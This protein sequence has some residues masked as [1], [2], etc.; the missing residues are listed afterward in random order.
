MAACGDDEKG[1]GGVSDAEWQA[2][3]D[4]QPEN[5]TSYTVATKS[6]SS[7]DKSQAEEYGEWE[8]NTVTVSIDKTN[9]IYVRV[10]KRETYNTASGEFD[11]STNT[12]YGFQY[13]NNYY[14]WYKQD[15]YETAQVNIS[16]KA[17][18]ISELESFDVMTNSLQAYAQPAM[19]SMF[20]YN[21]S[22]GSYELNYA[23]QS[24]SLKFNDD[25]VR[26]IFKETSIYANEIEISKKNETVNTIPNAVKTDVDN[27]IAE[28][29]KTE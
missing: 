15:G 21:S 9:Q 26:L 7:Y 18:F 5:Y 27:Y 24:V 1:G 25:S 3:L 20:K 23:G 12:T 8:N 11:V 29:E 4:F 14:T 2:M 17:D 19:K 10:N 13:R 28:Q 16:S 6:Y 22:T